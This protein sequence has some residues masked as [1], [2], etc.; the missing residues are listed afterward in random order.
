MTT[1]AKPNITV[2]ITP[3]TLADWLESR[4]KNPEKYKERKE[5]WPIFS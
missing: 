5:K 1:G 3:M 2:R 4:E